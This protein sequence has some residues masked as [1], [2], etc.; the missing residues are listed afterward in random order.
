MYDIFYVLSLPF[1]GVHKN[2]AKSGELRR[3][4]KIKN[5][6]CL[7]MTAPVFPTSGA[8]RYYSKERPN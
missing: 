3:F 5:R 7:K 4:Q 2:G 8:H 6:G 1:F